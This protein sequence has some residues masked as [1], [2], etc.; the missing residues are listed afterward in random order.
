LP[1]LPLSE[2]F[3][4]IYISNGIKYNKPSGH[5]KISA[6]FDND[7]VVISL[8]ENGIGISDDHKKRLFEV[9]YRG[10][11]GQGRTEGTGVGLSLVR[12]LVKALGS[13]LIV[14]SQLDKGSTFSFSLKKA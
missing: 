13:D 1:S 14:E 7:H 2:G 5:V 6:S 4:K 3:S 10:S 11:A 12:S 9:F 8:S